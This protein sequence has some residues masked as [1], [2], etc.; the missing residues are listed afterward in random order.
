M[1]GCSW[2]LDTY[3]VAV[4][5]LARGTDEATGMEIQCILYLL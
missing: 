2:A 1:G 5:T 4:D 3:K